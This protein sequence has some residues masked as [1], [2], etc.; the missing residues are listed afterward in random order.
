MFYFYDKRKYKSSCWV[1]LVLASCEVIDN[2]ALILQPTNQIA[3]RCLELLLLALALISCFVLEW[4]GG[5]VRKAVGSGFKWVGV[6]LRSG[7]NSPG[8]SFFTVYFIKIKS[9]YCDLPT[10]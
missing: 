8:K 7:L 10:N 9:K 5:G 4:V 2:D 3:V 6:H 1:V